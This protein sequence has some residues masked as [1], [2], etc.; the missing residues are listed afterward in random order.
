MSGALRRPRRGS[1]RRRL[2]VALLVCAGGLGLG[3]AAAGAEPEMSADGWIERMNEALLPGRSMTAKA[4]LSTTDPSGA[5]NRVDFDFAR[6]TDELG[7]HRTLIEVTAPDFWKGIVYQIIARPGEPLESWVWSPAVGRLRRIIGVHR[8]GEFL[9]SEFTYEDLGL[10]APLERRSGEVTKVVEEGKTWV[11][12]VSGPYHYYGRVQSYLDPD[13]GMPHRIVFYDRDGRRFREERF[14]EIQKFGD[15]R[16]PTVIEV[17]DELTGT[18]SRLV[19]H[20]V[21][22][23]VDIPPTL[24]TESI[25]RQKLRSGWQP[26]VPAPAE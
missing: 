9:G 15:H 4:V 8:T 3:A 14:R 19:F 5:T 7:I 21:K 17:K 20:G 1:R 13:T 18:S 12:L 2:A 10:V 23:D 25:V 11:L 16:F 6:L 22:F 26:H 24:Y